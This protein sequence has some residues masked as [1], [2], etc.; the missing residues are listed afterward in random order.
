LAGGA[1]IRV[2]ITFAK[3][4]LVSA[5]HD[6]LERAFAER[7]A[8]KVC[9]GPSVDSCP[10]IPKNKRVLADHKRHWTQPGID[11]L[12]AESDSRKSSNGMKTIPQATD[13][14]EISVYLVVEYYRVLVYELTPVLQSWNT[15]LHVH[16]NL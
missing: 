4:L 14:V 12:G 2:P 8:S 7:E 15:E 10:A 11:F 16:T 3:L 6:R 1:D 5:Q 9:G 13:S